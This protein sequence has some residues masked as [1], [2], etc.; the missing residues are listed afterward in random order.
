MLKLVANCITCAPVC[1][2]VQK[3]AKGGGLL[4]LFHAPVDWNLFQLH[5]RDFNQNIISKCVRDDTLLHLDN[6]DRLKM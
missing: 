1:S 5:V 2:V 3:R 6:R 4:F